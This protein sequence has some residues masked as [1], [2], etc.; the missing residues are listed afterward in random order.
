MH[1]SDADISDSGRTTKAILHPTDFSEASEAAFAHALEIALANQADLTILHVVPSRHDEV[2]WH[3]YP[4]VR[5]TLER[6]GELPPGSSHQ[7]VADRLGIKIK[8]AVGY[9]ADIVQAIVGFSRRGGFD[10]IVI[11]TD[12]NQQQPFWMRPHIAIPVSEETQLPTLYV[13]QGVRGCVSL[14]DGS[15]TLNRVLIPVDHRP[16]VQPSL[17]LIA[18]TLVNLGG[19]RADIALLHVGD[20]KRFPRIKPPELEELTWTK[21]TR[22]GDAASQI[23]R[24]AE[25]YNVDLIVM[26]TE[27]KKG[28]WDAVRGNTVQQVLW[29][30]PCPVFTVPAGIV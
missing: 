27:G 5:R 13:P 15:V 8:K 30:A 26:V 21:V 11:A 25:E 2:P 24:T 29:K 22:K 10:F 1:S 28:F 14:S 18:R 4:S 16:K 6:W 3:E 20:R 19:P 9:A 7:D 12:E 17:N 23:I